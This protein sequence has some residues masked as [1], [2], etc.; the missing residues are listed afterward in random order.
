MD[1]WEWMTAIM[2]VLLLANLMR[3]N[4]WITAIGQKLEYL[5]D[6]KV[7][8]QQ[9]QEHIYERIHSQITKPKNKNNAEEIKEW[10]ES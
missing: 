5:Y 10:D 2:V 1:Y 7:K 3:M 4:L 8:E 9:F 6:N